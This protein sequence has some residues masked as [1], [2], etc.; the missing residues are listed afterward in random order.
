[1]T[2]VGLITRFKS[3]QLRQKVKWPFQLKNLFLVYYFAELSFYLSLAM[4]LLY[5]NKR[6]DFT[7]QIVHHVATL[8]LLGK[9]SF[10]IDA[11]TCYRW[12]LHVQFYQNRDVGNVGTWH[13]GHFPRGGQTLCLC[14]ENHCCWYFICIFRHSIFRQVNLDFRL[15]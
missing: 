14:Q 9:I 4:T 3:C 15:A 2:T 7:E 1:M 13:L 12:E 6:K 10:R 8:L 11:L 5:D